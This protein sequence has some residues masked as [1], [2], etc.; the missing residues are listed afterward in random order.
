MPGSLRQRLPHILERPSSQLPGLV[1]TRASDRPA[2]G[3]RQDQ[4]SG[5]GRAHQRLNAFRLQP[6]Y[7]RIGR[8]PYRPVPY[9][10]SFPL[11][12]SSP[13]LALSPHHR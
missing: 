6:P 9:P 8:A 2:G 1:S 12:H 5:P 11:R 10:A 4:I 13:G 7:A 3:H